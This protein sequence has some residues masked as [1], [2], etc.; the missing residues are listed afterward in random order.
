MSHALARLAI[1]RKIFAWAASYPVKVYYGTEKGD[2]K[3]ETYLRCHLMPATTT[4]PY[5]H[6]DGTHFTGLYQVT[7]SC[8]PATPQNVPDAIVS[9]LTDLFP[10]N[11]E[12]E[13]D[14]FSGIIQTP[15]DR[16]PTIVDDNRYNV[17]VTI[18][19]RGEVSIQEE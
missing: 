7:I 4:S 11:S 8:N 12:L 1:E 6:N 17:P 13:A 16:G 18:P 3:L 10:V 19:Y 9:A 15:V 2:A 14:G 5:L